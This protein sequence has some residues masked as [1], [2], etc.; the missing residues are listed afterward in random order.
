MKKT[1]H[2]LMVGACVILAEQ[3][4][5]AQWILGTNTV[6]LAQSNQIGTSVSSVTA[7]KTFNIATNSVNRISVNGTSFQTRF[8]GNTSILVNNVNTPNANITSSGDLG[9]FAGSPFCIPQSSFAPAGEP[10]SASSATAVPVPS[11]GPGDNIIM[12]ARNIYMQSKNI[13][14]DGFGPV[15]PH[16]V[17]IGEVTTAP[18]SPATP[19]LLV[20]GGGT[21]EANASCASTFNDADNIGLVSQGNFGESPASSNANRWISLGARPTSTSIVDFNSYGYR[22]QWNNYAGDLAVQN[23]PTI[24]NVKD[25][26]LTWQDGLSTVSPS[27]TTYTSTPGLLVQFRNGLAPAGN[28]IGNLRFTVARYGMSGGMGLYQVNG[29]VVS[30]VTLNPSD[31]RLKKDINRMGNSLEIIKKLNPVTYGFKAEEFGDMGLPRTLQYGF[32]AQELEKVLPTHVSD[33]DN[34]YKAVNYTMLIPLLTKGMQETTTQLEQATAKIVTLEQQMNDMQKKNDELINQ[35]ERKGI[36]LQTNGSNISEQFFQNRPNPF[37]ESTTIS[38]NFIA[39]GNYKL[40]LTDLT[41]KLIKQY[42]NLQGKGE[43]KINKTDLPSAG[44]YL[45]S[46]ITENGEIAA[47]KQLILEN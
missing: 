39:D 45:Y 27:L 21:V 4:L 32:I 28:P 31:V 12:A 7:R 38:Y 46:I 16:R 8:L 23:H 41:G 5:Q 17:L 13:I 33:L 34:G 40:V 14:P 25:V 42:A 20:R 26:S 24:A 47:S 11:S 15:A 1:I 29:M 36:T 18:V 2:L 9:L 22:T 43:V 30:P 35:L 44:I 3:T 37:S 10:E 6:T 19:K